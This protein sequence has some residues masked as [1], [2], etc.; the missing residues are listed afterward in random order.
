MLS[1]NF[2]R[3]SRG[4]RRALICAILGLILGAPARTQAQ[5]AVVPMASVE[6]LQLA[7]PV[8]MEAPE[9]WDYLKPVGNLLLA[10]LVYW[11]G[12]RYILH[13]DFS[14]IGS[15]TIIDNFEQGFGWDFDAFG[16]NQFGHPYQGA[17][18]HSG[19]R[20][21]G[22]GFWGAI[23]YTLLGS[24]Q[25]ELFME[26]TRPAYNDVVTTSVGGVALGEVLFR[27]SSTLLDPSSHGAQRAV[28]EG[29]ALLINPVY[30]LARLASSDAERHAPAGPS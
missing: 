5:V 8:A 9:G 13:N 26:N 30:G 16:T 22:F 14:Y 28:R 6:P 19:A 23:P 12:S 2:K 25:W 27:L 7:R 1:R 21:V 10:N 20:A 15:S 17:G 24:L 3:L 29:G 4:V 11:V 18:Y